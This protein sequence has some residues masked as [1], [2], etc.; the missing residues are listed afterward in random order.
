[1]DKISEIKQLIQATSDQPHSLEELCAKAGIDYESIRKTFRRQ[2]GRK[3]VFLF[4]DDLNHRR[5]N[6]Q[7][8]LVKT[9]GSGLRQLTRFRR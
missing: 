5:G 2:E 1:M 6:G 7:L 8:W 4:W 9:D 3:L